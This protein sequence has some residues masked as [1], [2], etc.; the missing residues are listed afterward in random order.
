MYGMNNRGFRLKVGL[1]ALNN[2]DKSNEQVAARYADDGLTA[3][4]VARCRREA[5]PVHERYLRLYGGPAYYEAY[6]IDK[7]PDSVMAWVGLGGK[8]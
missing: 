2:R 4:D 1:Y 3:D 8:L 6:R 7:K 5:A